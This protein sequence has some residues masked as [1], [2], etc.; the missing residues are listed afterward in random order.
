[1]SEKNAWDL[2]IAK[3]K[4]ELE[5]VSA[6]LPATGLFLDKSHEKGKDDSCPICVSER[7]ILLEKWYVKREKTL[8]Q[9]ASIF[10]FDQHV[11]SEHCT[12]N[13]LG[14]KRKNNTQAI[15]NFVLEKGVEGLSAGTM[16]VT[17]KDLAWAVTHQDKL[18][19]RIVEK[20]RVEVAPVVHIHTSIPG[21][22]GVQNKDL[23]EKQALEHREPLMIPAVVLETSDVTLTEPK[24]NG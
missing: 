23:K 7:R 20:S 6:P 2:E 19:G 1:M 13:G 22:G 3:I 15:I 12:A 16:E 14:K 5:K 18:L 10:G 11:I 9:L 8:K 17:M 4:G 21:V 24:E